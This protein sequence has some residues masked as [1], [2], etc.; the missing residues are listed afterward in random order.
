MCANARSPGSACRADS[1][2]RAGTAQLSLFTKAS[3]ETVC[4]HKPPSSP[5]WG[6]DWPVPVCDS[7]DCLSLHLKSFWGKDSHR[8]EFCLLRVRCNFSVILYKIVSGTGSMAHV[9]KPRSRCVPSTGKGA[10]SIS[11]RVTA[12]CHQVGHESVSRRVVCF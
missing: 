2:D 9:P 8:S 6:R 4:Q 1:G 3:P 11:R 5:V 10:L 7:F 12:A